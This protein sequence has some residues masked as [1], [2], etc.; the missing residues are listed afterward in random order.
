MTRDQIE[1]FKLRVHEVCRLAL[2]GL[3]AEAVA[4]ASVALA[5]VF[6]AGTV[7]APSYAKGYIAGQEAMQERAVNEI[8]A[9]IAEVRRL[10]RTAESKQ[11]KEA[12]TASNRVR[13]MCEA[14]IRA[15]PIEGKES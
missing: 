1:E 10:R 4:S 5:E 13:S 9:Q 8:T 6:D 12:L 7:D 2:L 3:D 14:A 15:L 11:T